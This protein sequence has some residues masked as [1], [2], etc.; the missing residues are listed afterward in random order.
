MTFGVLIRNTAWRDIKEDRH[1]IKLAAN[2]IW[3]FITEHRYAK[4]GICYGDS[5]VC[6]CMGLNGLTCHQ[7]VGIVYYSSAIIFFYIENLAAILMRSLSY[8][9]RGPKAAAIPKIC[10]VTQPP[11]CCRACRNLLL[12][13]ETKSVL[14]L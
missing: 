8:G 4:C 10:Y 12:I 13:A 3:R 11:C 1:F 5:P 14:L 6:P 2:T 7:R 9:T